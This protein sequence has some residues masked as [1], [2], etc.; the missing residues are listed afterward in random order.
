M[1]GIVF[2]WWYIYFSVNSTQIRKMLR[3]QVELRGRWKALTAFFKVNISQQEEVRKHWRHTWKARLLDIYLFVCLCMLQ[4]TGNNNLW[5]LVLCCFFFQ[6]MLWRVPELG[7]TPW[8]DFLVDWWFVR[9]LK[10]KL[11]HVVSRLATVPLTA[12]NVPIWIVLMIFACL[13]MGCLALWLQKK[14]RILIMIPSFF[15]VSGR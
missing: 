6:Q 1:W 9:F 4:T 11:C 8:L 15:C 7:K 12:C 10:N 2:G 13:W 5:L 14:S 3:C